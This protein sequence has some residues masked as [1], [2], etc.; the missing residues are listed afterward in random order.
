M[1]QNMLSSEF[2]AGREFEFVRIIQMLEAQIG[3]VESASKKP[4]KEP[5]VIAWHDALALIKGEN[6]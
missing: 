4:E 3:L 1:K 6:K 5:Y 2:A